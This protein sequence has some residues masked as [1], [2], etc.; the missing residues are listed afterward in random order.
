MADQDH[1]GVDQIVGAGRVHNGTKL[2]GPQLRARLGNT[3]FNPLRGILQVKDSLS[4][5][6]P[7]AD[8]STHAAAA[9]AP[10][11]A[12]HDLGADRRVDRLTA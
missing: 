6:E 2:T 7:G 1:Q 4:V 3:V 9:T 8:R 12:G 11:S 10:G 5:L